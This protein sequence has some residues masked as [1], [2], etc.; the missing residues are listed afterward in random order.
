MG[1]A[2]ET[3]PWGLVKAAVQLVLGS[4]G[5]E[6]VEVD[7]HQRAKV[8]NKMKH[9]NNHL[10]AL[11]KG[12]NI[13]TDSLGERFL[14]PAEAL[15]SL[16]PRLSNKPAGILPA[17]DPSHLTVISEHSLAPK[18]APAE[19]PTQ[20]LSGDALASAGVVNDVPARLM[21]TQTSLCR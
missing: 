5:E 2:A 20:R 10:E 3:G 12:E 9:L 11:C 7:Q 21:Y 4:S 16:L 18:A 8:Q 17:I 15:V 19:P 6:K 14:S 13:H 1:A